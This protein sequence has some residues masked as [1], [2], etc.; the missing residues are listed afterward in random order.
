[1]AKESSTVQGMRLNLMYLSNIW[2]KILGKTGKSKQYPV[3]THCT[4]EIGTFTV[5]ILYIDDGKCCKLPRAG[6]VS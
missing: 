6:V 4:P 2:G 1:M 3:Q 5:R